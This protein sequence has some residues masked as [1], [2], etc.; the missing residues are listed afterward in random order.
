MKKELQ[1]ILGLFSYYSK[2]VS[3]FSE[4]IQ[5]LF[6][7]EA[8]PLSNATISAFRLMK[9]K[10]ADATLQPIDKAVPFTVE[11]DA[12]DFTIAATLNQNGKPVAFH[13]R[14]L[15]TSEQRHL[16]VEKEAYAVVEALRKWKHLLLGK[17]FTLITDQRS[18]SFML[19]MK[20]L[21]K[22]KNDKILR[23]RLELAAFDFTIIYR[24][25]K[26]NFAPDTLSRAISA[27]VSFLSLKSLTNL[28][29]SLCHPE[30]LDWLTMSKLKT[31]R[32]R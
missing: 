21:S 4:I 19:D 16:A 32:F 10:L 6:Q 15:S 28:H 7:N 30:L 20:H 9:N 27:S 26:L 11:T 5:P 22:I 8:F 12:S 14:T 13:A 2:W 17:H 24:P 25:G 1:R 31:C 18:V 23:W 3:N 29:E